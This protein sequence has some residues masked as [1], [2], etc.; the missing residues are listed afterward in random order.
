MTDDYNPYVN[1]ADIFGELVFNDQTLQERS[2][3][4]PRTTPIGF[5]PSTD[6]LQKSMIHSSHLR[7]L[8][9][10]P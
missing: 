1:P 8:P 4:A 7:F 6:S 3:K 2:K 10:R 9:E 5:S